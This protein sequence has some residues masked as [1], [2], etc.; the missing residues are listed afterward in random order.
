MAHRVVGTSALKDDNLLESDNSNVSKSNIVNIDDYR[1][2]EDV[3]ESAI[4]KISK[5]FADKLPDNKDLGDQLSFVIKSIV[6]E[7]AVK[8]S[9]E[10][11]DDI[12]SIIAKNMGV[13]ESSYVQ[14]EAKKVYLEVQNWKKEN[15]KEVDDFKKKEFVKS[16]EE[17]VKKTN[18]DLN[19]KQLTSLRYYANLVS[20]VYINDNKYKTNHTAL[21]EQKDVAINNNKEAFGPGKIENGWTDL[22]GTFSLLQKKPNEL[23]VLGQ[24]HKELTGELKGINLPNNLRQVRSF[25]NLMSGLNDVKTNSLFSKTQQYLGWADKLNK[26]TG[27]LLG[28]NVTRIGG[29]I[30]TKIGNQALSEFATNSLGVLAKEGFQKGFTTVLNEVVSGGVKKFGEKAAVQIAGKVAVKVGGQIAAEATIA[31]VGGVATGGLLTLAIAAWEGIKWAK[32]KLEGISEKLGLNAKKFLEENF[33][34]VGGK[35]VGALVT[36]LALPTLLITSISISVLAPMLIGVFG[37]MFVFSLFQGNMVSSLVPPKGEV[38]DSVMPEESSDFIASSGNIVLPPT[39][40]KDGVTGEMIV[41][42]ARSLENKVCYWFGGGHGHFYKEPIKGVDPNWGTTRFGNNYSPAGTYRNVYGLDCS[43]FVKWVYYQYNINLNGNI[44][45]WYNNYPHV[46]SSQLQLGDL[47]F[48]NDF[49]HV[50]IYVG[51]GKFAQAGSGG[52]LNICKGAPGYV[53]EGITPSFKM[54]ARIL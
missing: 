18:P 2:K 44:R 15:W 34:K 19:K 48:T 42:M 17:E 6:R 52:Y 36:V 26:W 54:F 11:I 32:K 5:D 20:S 33:G 40:N 22:Q 49:G 45:A 10:E 21:D 38:I 16:F 12:A 7:D 31:T 3:V 39:V 4:N 29:N 9:T 51:N 41:G 43:G 46:S 13:T 35:V 50:G 47:G 8:T 23:K 1:K 53:K 27:G 24:I 28:D 37:L 30:I 14:V 25:E